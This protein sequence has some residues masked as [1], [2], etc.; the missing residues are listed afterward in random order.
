M[1][2]RSICGLGGCGKT[3]LAVEF[4]WR[5]RKHFTGGVFWINGESDENVRKSVAENLALLNIPAS[6]NE[7][8]DDALNRFLALLSN[9]NCPWL[10][11]VDN[12]DE[13][14]S[15][16]CPS[17]VMKICNGPWQ[18][19]A[20][21]PK[22][23]QILFTTRQNARNIKTLLKLSLKDCLELQSFTEKEGALFLMQRTG[24]EE[25]SLYKEAVDLAKELGG[26]PLALEQA[27]AYISALPITCTFKSYLDK[28]REVRLRLLKHQPVTA[29]SVEAQHRLSVHTTWEMNFEFVAEK[30]PAAATM[31]RIA[32]FLESENIPFEV[33][34]P[35]LPAIDQVELREAACSKI[36][37]SAV[38]K[39]LTCY[40]LFSV[41]QQSKVFSVHKLVQEV[42]RDSLTSRIR[43]ETLT[44]A[45][46][47]LHCALRKKSESC[48]RFDGHYVINWLEVDKE[49]KN[50]LIALLLNS[51]K[52]K[53]HLQAEMKLSMDRFVDCIGSD[54]TFGQLFD[55]TK[56]LIGMNIFLVKLK[57]EFSEFVLQVQR[58]RSEERR[59]GK[60]C[61]SRWSP[62]H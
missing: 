31:M 7:N 50:I 52:L 24:L 55:L 29:L 48:L 30:S 43:T 3:S 59:V 61:R 4:A 34:N 54:D 21:A 28:Y 40:S 26:L 38:L 11:V 27:A 56:R 5:W 14:R 62:Y 16:K 2:F 20:K 23:G 39:V 42:V 10:L 32:S 19:N 18:R 33:I 58:M 17:G 51:R 15:P 36:D 9:K 6:T 44:A 25:E 13:L 49:D 35:G 37:I 12:A 41:D 1:L 22:N 53:D 47:V 46:R 45:M 8:V 57:A 60:E